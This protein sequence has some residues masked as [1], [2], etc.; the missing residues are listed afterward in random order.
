MTLSGVLQLYSDTITRPGYVVL[1]LLVGFCGALL[2]RVAAVR[3]V[4]QFA[5]PSLLIFLLGVTL[6]LSAV[7]LVGR[8]MQR[9][10]LEVRLRSH[11]LFCAY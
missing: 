6:L 3:I 4:K 1:T 5:H 7:L 8:V 11:D 10:A 2:G 9:D